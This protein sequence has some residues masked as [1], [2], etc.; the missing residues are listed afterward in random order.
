MPKTNG[1]PAAL[2]LLAGLGAH[3]R[4]R[5]RPMV[6]CGSSAVFLESSLPGTH[7]SRRSRNTTSTHRKGR[8]SPGPARHTARTPEQMLHPVQVLS[9]ASSAIHHQ[10]FHGSAREVPGRT[11]RPSRGSTPNRPAPRSISSSN[12]HK[13]GPPG[14][15]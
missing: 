8:G 12:S 14:P 5:D 11:P 2:D 10:F 4:V 1:S 15:R 13:G 7:R 9:P 3:A 6:I